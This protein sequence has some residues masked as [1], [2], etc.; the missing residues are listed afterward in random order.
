MKKVLIT[1]ANSYIGINVEK[2]LKFENGQ[3]EVDTISVKTDAWKMYDM[4]SYD[5]VFHVAG[6]A[7]AD[8][9]KTTEALE[10][11][12]YKINT[13]LAIEVAEKA[14]KE[15][16]RQFIFMS[17]IIVYGNIEHITPDT[18]P[19]PA[20]FYGDSKWKADCIIRELASDNFK[21][22]VLRPPMVYGKNSKGNYRLL[23]LIAKH[24]LVFPK[25]NNKRSMLYIGNLCEFVKMIID[26]EECGV[27]FPQNQKHVSTSKLVSEIANVYNHK[28]WFSSFMNVVVAVGKKMPGKVGRLCDKAFGDSWYEWSMSEYLQNYNITNFSN[29]IIETETNRTF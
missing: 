11:M 9:G 14:K 20:N 18:Q 21:V 10:T 2:R 7:H 13:N 26:N 22:V 27:F 24:S 4:R 23:S 19:K 5:T 8:I 29:S 12:Y 28:I 15:G 1:G 17:S 25:V 16:V 6:I 3:Y